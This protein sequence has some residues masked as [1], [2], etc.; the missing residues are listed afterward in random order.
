MV[1]HTG[2][3]TYIRT[4]FPHLPELGGG[5]GY[6]TLRNPG[7]PT[8]GT[9]QTLDVRSRPLDL[10]NHLLAW[11]LRSLRT[12]L[13]HVPF[14]NVPLGWSGRLVITIHDLIPLTIP[15]TIPS[16]V[17]R[18]AYRLWLRAAVRKA[19]IIVTVS[20]HSRQDII[21]LLN[22]PPDRVAVVFPAVDSH[23]R[24]AAEE[25]PLI[26]LRRQLR[27]EQFFLYVGRAKPHKNLPRLLRAFRVARARSASVLVIVGPQPPPSNLVE[28]VRNL[29]L[30]DSVRFVGHISDEELPVYYQAATAVVLPSLYEGFGLPALEGMACG[31]PV[32]AS[33][34]TAVPEVVG[35]AAL[36][37]EPTDVNAIAEGIVRIAHDRDLRYALRERGLARSRTFS[38]RASAER[39][40]ETYV[41]ILNGRH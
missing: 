5:Y 4:L 25:G 1:R 15:E 40:G 39:L 2:V 22:I 21:R 29:G 24:P 36:L 27:A 11:E 8:V 13:L 33:N 23:V 20:E 30:A 41:S 17:R 12:G 9:W 10:S 7:L 37:V 26:A 31:T 14:F 18:A 3:G 6:L 35:D 38:S 16:P 32:L 28:D 19:D 34:A